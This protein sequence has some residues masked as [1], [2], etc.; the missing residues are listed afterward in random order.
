MV[1]RGS[2]RSFGRSITP[3]V[4][5]GLL[6]TWSE[7]LAPSLLSSSITPKVAMYALNWVINSLLSP[8]FAWK[9]VNQLLYLQTKMK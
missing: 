1:A 2:P 6:R 5:R 4:P 3:E 8:F 9:T 7:P